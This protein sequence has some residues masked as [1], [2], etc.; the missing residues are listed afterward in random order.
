[1]D[2]LNADAPLDTV[3]KLF[4][5]GRH[6]EGFHNA[7]ESFYGTPAWNVRSCLQLRGPQRLTDFSV[8]G[9]SLMAMQQ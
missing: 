8:T 4:W 6:G 5:F 3:Y 7:A 1:M 2:S 9:L